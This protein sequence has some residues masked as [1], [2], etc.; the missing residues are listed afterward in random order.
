MGWLRYIGEHSIVIY[1]S[2]FIFMAGAR[3]VL[4]KFGIIDDVGVI[5]LLVT[6]A[7]VIG[8]LVLYWTTRRTP[9]RYL[10]ERPSWAM[11]KYRPKTLAPAE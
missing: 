8:P 7:G 4:L 6:L 3:T 5:S 10:F 11:L 1:L 2:F 9:L